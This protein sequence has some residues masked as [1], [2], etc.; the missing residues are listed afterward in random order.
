[1]HSLI[2]TPPSDRTKYID[3]SKEMEDL[4]AA[5]ASQG[6]TKPPDVGVEVDHH[7]TCFVPSVKERKLYE[8]DGDRRGPL[9]RAE[10]REDLGDFDEKAL[11]LMRQ[12]VEKEEGERKIYFSVMALVEESSKWLTGC[13]SK[14]KCPLL[15]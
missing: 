14:N 1:M 6:S 4:Y 12:I 11:K 9:E 13:A 15:Q 8:L 10:L 5:A 7:Y 2:T 3:T